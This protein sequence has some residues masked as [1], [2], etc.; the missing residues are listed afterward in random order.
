MKRLK[1]FY[2]S[3]LQANEHQ[4]DPDAPPPRPKEYRKSAGGG[5]VISVL[6]EV[7]TEAEMAAQKLKISEEYA[8]KAYSR[9]VKDITESINSA[10]E[11]KDSV[12]AQVAKLKSQKAEAAESLTANNAEL[13]KLQDL[14]KAHHEDC[15]SLLENFDKRKKD[16]ED[17]MAVILEAKDMVSGA[18]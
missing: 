17:E 3:L 9:F 8:S 4:V 12:E 1:D 2:M 14:L 5:R 10:K 11:A 18:S 7:A 15:D 16:L 13:S 6:A